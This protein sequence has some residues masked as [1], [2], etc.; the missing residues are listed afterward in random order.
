MEKN[1]SPY[2]DI[3][4]GWI[5]EHC[6]QIWNTPSIDIR[7]EIHRTARNELTGQPAIPRDGNFGLERLF[8]SDD[9]RKLAITGVP[10]QLQDLKH[11]HPRRCDEPG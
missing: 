7:S 3:V 4:V 1:C 2:P 10:C 6:R 8:L 11:R 5:V 9:C